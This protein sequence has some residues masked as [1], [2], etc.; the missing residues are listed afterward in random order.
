MVQGCFSK[1]KIEFCKDPRIRADLG[2]S[3]IPN[4]VPHFFARDKTGF[5]SRALK[6]CARFLD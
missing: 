3:E 6:V 2:D 1:I 4:A 5:K